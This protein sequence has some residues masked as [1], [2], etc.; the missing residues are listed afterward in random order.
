M[1]SRAAARDLYDVRNMIHF[2]LFDE[3]ENEMLR[4]CIVFYAAISAKD[5]NKFFDIKRIDSITQSKIKTDL[6][7]VIRRRDDFDLESAKKLVKS[8]VSDLM[9]LTYEE[10]EFLDRFESGEYIPELLFYDKEILNRIKNHPMAL[11]KTR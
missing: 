2:G 6:L 7:P 1:L 10:N 9:I 3:S 4:K 5:I 8:Y 11:W